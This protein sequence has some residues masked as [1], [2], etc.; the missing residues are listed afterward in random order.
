MGVLYYTHPNDNLSNFVTPT[1]ISG[2]IATG[3]PPDNAINRDPS[4]P[5]KFDTQTFRILW[6]FPAP[7]TLRWVHLV[8]HNFVA[9]MG[10]LNFS[11]GTT[12]ATT[13]FTQAL[14]VPPYAEDFFPTNIH[15]I[16]SAPQ[17]YKY[18]ALEGT[19][20][21]SVPVSI[22]EVAIYST[23]REMPAWTLASGVEEAEEHPLVEHQTDIGVST[24]FVYGT[25]RRW[26]RGEVLHESGNAEKVRKLRRDA[27]GR[28]F[29]FSII[30]DLPNGEAWYVRFEQT[31]Q[32][33]QYIERDWISRLP[34]AFEE[35][36][37]G[38]KPTPSAV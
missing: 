14:T 22:G 35:V 19:T 27:F 1:V 25:R 26:L 20:A 32:V 21:N 38:L 30:P 34:L 24:I 9:G 12:A 29:P 13:N 17:T 10:G 2:T 4:Y 28:G 16:F 31:Q 5:M 8:H 15:A 6:N 7:Q 37:R 23:L 36:S 3:Y 18:A 11:M 33:R